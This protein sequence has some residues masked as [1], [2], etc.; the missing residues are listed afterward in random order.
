MRVKLFAV[1]HAQVVVEPLIRPEEWRLS[2][3][4][5]ASACALARRPE[6]AG[7][8][9]AA[10]HHSPQHKTAQTAAAMRQVLAI[11]TF[12]E[13]DLVEL[14]MDCGFL[15]TEAFEARVGHYLEEGRDPAFEDY[16]R[17]RER[18]VGCVRRILSAARVGHSVAIVSHGRILTVLFSALC[19][20][21]LGHREWKSIQ[22]PDLSVVDLEAETV[23]HGFLAG[24][25]IRA[26]AVR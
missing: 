5:I 22:M 20:V 8:G 1:R 24:R 11:P 12:A 17:A 21:R 18:I 2:A 25:R 16:E 26:A 10:I 19:G 3:A 4:G 7:A 23:T 6:W 14:R 13:A 9:V 15:G